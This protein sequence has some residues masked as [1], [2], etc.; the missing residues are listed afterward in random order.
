MPQHKSCKKRMKQDAARRDRN[1][2]QRSALRL[3]IRR[4]R[5]LAATDRAAAY[6]GL[7]STLDKAAGKRVIS[8]NH[9]ARLKSRLAPAA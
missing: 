9:A 2:S 8:K 1:R 7:Q 5:E 6:Q 4:Y 3:A